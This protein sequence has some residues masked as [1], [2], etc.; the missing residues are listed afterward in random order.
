LSNSFNKQK[1]VYNWRLRMKRSN[2]EIVLP[3]YLVLAIGILA[4]STASVF[5][6]YA[7]QLAPSLAIGGFRLLIAAA[8]LAPFAISRNSSEIKEFDRRKWILVIL[9]GSFLA[10]HFAAWITSLEYTSVASSVVLVTTAPLW[11]AIFSPIFLKEKITRLT[12][13]G[14]I[15]ALVGS[16]IVT[17]GNYCYFAGTQLSCEGF[18]GLSDNRTIYGDLLALLGAFFSAGYLLV[19]RRLRK[20]TNLLTYT[21]TVYAVAALCMAALMIFRHVTFIGYSPWAYILFFALAVIPQL[22]GHTSFN[23]ALRYKS[24]ALVSVALLGEPVG[25]VILAFFLLKETP[26]PAEIAGGIIILLGIYLVSRT[27]GE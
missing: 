9:A 17:A 6:R 20:T 19:G 22:L 24:S 21:F 14:I 1:G 15:V 13:L 26:S 25:T 4:V 23:Y 3:P 11:V 16:M 27:N 8:I 10:I 2:G 7:Q 12:I 5:I 18:G